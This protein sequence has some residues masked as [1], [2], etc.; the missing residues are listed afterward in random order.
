[1][2]N[3]EQ[4]KQRVVRFV[5]GLA[6]AVVFIIFAVISVSVAPHSS[7][8]GDDYDMYVTHHRGVEREKKVIVDEATAFDTAAVGT[9]T[10]SAPVQEADTPEAD[11]PAEPVEEGPS[12][13]DI[14]INSWE[15]MLVN[16]ASTLDASYEPPEIVYL[17]MTA[18]DRDKP[19]AYDGNRLPVDSRIADALLD[20]AQGCKDAGLPVFLSSSYRSYSEQ[21]ALLQRKIGQGYDYDTA[22]TIV[23]APGTSEHQTGLCCDITDRYRE[24]KDSSL[25]ETETYKWLAAHCTDYGFIVR[26]PADKSGGADTVTGVIYEPWHFR[27]VGVEVAKYITENNLCLEEFVALYA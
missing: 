10:A 11:V 18:D 16:T 24:L 9:G 23:A 12:L 5:G 20:M 14:D 3:Q 8:I 2:N 22:I 6:F 21:D 1:M 15:Y 25:E 4:I 19:T 7:D 13:P 27:Y 17:N 26:Y